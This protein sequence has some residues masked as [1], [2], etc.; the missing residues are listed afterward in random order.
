MM[1]GNMNLREGLVIIMVTLGSEVMPLCNNFLLM[2]QSVDSYPWN[3]TTGHR[4]VHRHW[5]CRFSVNAYES[6]YSKIDDSGNIYESGK[7]SSSVNVVF[8]TEL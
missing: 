4:F 3:V 7:I 5:L 1:V 2:E 8:K 6:E